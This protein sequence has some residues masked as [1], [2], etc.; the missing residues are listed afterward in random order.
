MEQT[1]KYS[2][3]KIYYLYDRINKR[4]YVGSTCCSLK[5][6]LCDHKYDYKAWKGEAH[7]QLPRSYRTSFD[8]LCQDNYEHGILEE[9]SCGSRRELEY[10]ETEWINA[11]RMKN[12]QV[13]NLH[14]PN[15]SV[16]P[17]VLPHH[18]FVLP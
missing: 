5:K 9:F 11:F 8:I 6:R 12:V 15:L 16:K 14:I 7:N 18:F 3:S 2:N 10:R 1:N 13:V 17:P 4:I